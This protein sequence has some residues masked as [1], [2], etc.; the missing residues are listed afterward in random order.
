MLDYAWGKTP[1]ID[2]L[3]MDGRYRYVSCANASSHLFYFR[4]SYDCS[5]RSPLCVHL[6]VRVARYY[7]APFVGFALLSGDLGCALWILFAFGWLGSRSDCAGWVALTFGFSPGSPTRLARAFSASP[8][9]L[10]WRLMPHQDLGPFYLR[11][12]WH[13]AR[14]FAWAE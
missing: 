12:Q 6:G 1:G 7:S 10:S 3:T 14:H 9:T 4:A 5:Y 2:T 11:R 13:L 8:F